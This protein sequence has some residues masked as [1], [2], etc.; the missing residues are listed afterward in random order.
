M[1][2]VRDQDGRRVLPGTILESFRKERAEFISGRTSR[3]EGKVTVKWTSGRLKG[4]TGEYYPSVFG[5]PPITEE[6]KA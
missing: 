3:G 5:L 6:T 1:A 2:I 4:H